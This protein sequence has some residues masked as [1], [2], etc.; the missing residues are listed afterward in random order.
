LLLHEYGGVWVDATLFCNVPL[1]SWL[2]AQITQG[3]FAFA[4]PAPDRLLSSWFIA[5][6]PGNYLV[7]KWAARVAAY[8]AT[9]PKSHDYFWFH[10]L[11]GALCKTDSQARSLWNA[12]S[13]ISADG[14]HALLANG[15]FDPATPVIK[16]T[17][18]LDTRA[19]PPGSALR[20]LLNRSTHLAAGIMQAQPATGGLTNF[21]GLKTGTENLGD[22]IQI[23]AAEMLLKRAGV[24]IRQRIDRDDD[25]ASGTALGEIPL[26]TCIILNGWFKTNPA[27]WPPHPNLAPVYLGFHIRLFQAPSLVSE[28]ALENYRRYGPIGCRDD[29]TLSLLRG[30]GVDAYL[31]H[32]LSLILPRRLADASAQ[33]EIFIVSRDE[34]IL[35][36]IPAALGPVTFIS[37]Y[38]G[39]R[40]F[41]ANMEQAAVLLQRY[42]GSA[43]LIITTLLHCALPAIAMGI[44]VIVFYPLNPEAQHASDMERFSTL[45]RMLK[46]HD[47]S[48]AAQLDWGGQIVDI[49]AMKLALIERFFD[50]S[51]N[52]VL[53]PPAAIGPIAAADALPVPTAEE[54]ERLALEF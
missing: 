46:I 17:H 39:E 49:S 48:E 28:A 31:S 10:H 13:E 54:M 50:L 2:P 38:A 43:K 11:F 7:T 44:P 35:S 9:R 36:Y 37:H 30:H 16:L 40:D 3:F 1:D 19:S 8:W 25:I 52:W 12:V 47:F 53:P 51:R 22:H 32:C 29:Y 15:S 18:R 21:I 26:G 23:L 6:T 14:P 24:T 27:E 45:Q 4:K 33:T 42:A 5:C 41:V 20:E 34:R